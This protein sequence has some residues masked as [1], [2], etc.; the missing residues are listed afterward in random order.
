[1][2]LFSAGDAASPLLHP[3]QLDAVS[4]LGEILARRRGAILA[5]DVGLGKSYIAAAL[6][7][8]AER[9]GVNTT[10]LVPSNL[11]PQWRRLAGEF[12]WSPRI[13]THD[14]LRSI[15]TVPA[16]EDELVIVDEA[17]RFRNPATKR[18]RS[19]ASFAVGRVPLLITATPL[20][21]RAMDIESLIT[22]FAGDD[23]FR[24]IGVDSIEEA[25]MNDDGEAARRVIG[26][27]MLRRT[28]SQLQIA[29]PGL[30]R[31]IVRYSIASQA[32]GVERWLRSL[33]LKVFDDAVA[34]EALRK[35]YYRRFVS[36]PAALVESLT[37]LRKY[38]VRALD[39]SLRG[40]ALKPREFQRLFA[41]GDEEHAFQDVM[42]AELWGLSSGPVDSDS[43]RRDIA[44][45][46]AFK[47]RLAEMPDEKL[48]LLGQLVRTATTPVIIFTVAIA[49]ALA[50][51]ASLPRALRRGVVSSRTSRDER[52]LLVSPE[53][54]IERF[55]SGLID[56]LVTTD[57]ASEGLNLQVA[58]TVIH[59]DLPWTPVRIDQRNGRARRVASRVD[60]VASIYLIPDAAVDRRMRQIVLAKE[61]LRRSFLGEVVAGDDAVSPLSLER[62]LARELRPSRLSLSSPQAKLLRRLRGEQ[63]STIDALDLLTRRFRRGTEALLAAIAEEALPSVVFASVMPV[64]R[65][66]CQRADWNIGEPLTS[67]VEE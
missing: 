3:Y 43:L 56:V 11:L 20:C 42:F 32:R 1:M 41:A 13:D 33:E 37:R 60:T 51:H 6:G 29:L 47:T 22:L 52:N 63:A 4:R 24:D 26:A 8:M 62:A 66:E 17:H 28:A 31:K 23:A 40:I 19:L 46:D 48:A 7:V 27:C 64:L 61:R 30:G 50:I 15:A 44:A 14:R 57:L 9:C 18:Y 39:S 16:E 10:V 53:I 21:N 45:I 49:S 55:R 38:L 54:V 67:V 65:R 34:L 35:I 58:A 2:S 12:A 59:Y 25:F 36:S 5:D